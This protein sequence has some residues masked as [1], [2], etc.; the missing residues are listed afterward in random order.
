MTSD[1]IALTILSLPEP[2]KQK[3]LKRWWE[4]SEHQ[5]VTYFHMPKATFDALPKRAVIV[6]SD[7]NDLRIPTKTLL[8]VM[9]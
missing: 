5:G 1:D 6:E 9:K 3:Y 7:E 4:I 2:I 8:G